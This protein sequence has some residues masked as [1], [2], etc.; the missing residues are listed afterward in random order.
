MSRENDTD[1]GQQV[2]TDELERLAAQGEQD[3]PAEPVDRE[4]AGELSAISTRLGFGEA[5]RARSESAVDPSEVTHRTEA[6]WNDLVELL[7]AEIESATS[8]RQAAVLLYEL[9]HLY[10]MRLR[11]PDR[12]LDAYRRSHER[13]PGLAVNARAL[14]RLLAQAGDASAAERVLSAELSGASNASERV[15]VRLER[16]QLLADQLGEVDRA[17]DELHK[18]LEIDSD[19]G[20]VIQLLRELRQRGRDAGQVELLLRRQL[21]RAEDQSLRALLLTQIGA[22]K[23]AHYGDVEGASKLYQTALSADPGNSHAKRSL[24]RIARVK[25]DRRAAVKLCQ[26]LAAAEE[27]PYAAALLWEAAHLYGE[28]PR[29]G[30]LATSTLARAVELAPTDR[31][32]LTN[33]AQAYEGSRRWPELV[34]TL[35]LIAQQSLDP[36][37]LASTRLRIARL[38]AERLQ[39]VEGAIWNAREAFQLDAGHHGV[40]STLG[41]LYA[42]HGRHA[43]LLELLAAEVHSFDDPERRAA[44]AYRM[45]TIYRQ[46]LDDPAS[47][48]KACEH[49]LELRSGYRP[50]LSAIQE[51]YL[52]QERYEDLVETLEGQVAA[53]A[54]PEEKVVLL[55]RIA[56]L[57]ERSLGDPAAALSAYERMIAIEPANLTA[58]QALRRIYAVGSRW[59]DFVEI[60]RAESDYTP[61]RWR[62]AALLSEIA[63]VYEQRLELPDEALAS[64]LA[65][66]DQ[67]PQY[68]PAL[69]LAGRLL[70]ENGDFERLLAL[71]WQELEA[72]EDAAHRAWL[73]IKIGRVL[74]ERLDRTDDAVGVWL[75]AAKGTDG[76]TAALDLADRA[77]RFLSDTGLQLKVLA[78]Q[79]PP[80][81]PR[82]RSLYHRRMAHALW[83]EG[84]EI[85]AVEQWQSS[86]L[87]AE[88]PGLYELTAAM[89]HLG[90]RRGLVALLEATLENTDGGNPRLSLLHRLIRAFAGLPHESH[91][92]AQTWGR[93]LDQSPRDAIALRQLEILSAQLGRWRDLVAVT[94]LQREHSDDEDFRLGCALVIAAVREDRLDDLAGATQAAIEVLGR[95][96]THSEALATLERH[97]RTTGNADELLQVY[98]R[99]LKG[100][101]TAAE[102]AAMLCASAAVH[103][104]SDRMERACE[105]YRLAIDVMPSYLPAVRGWFRAAVRL[106]DATQMARALEL[107]ARSSRAAERQAACW[108]D[109]AQLWELHGNDPEQAVKG[110]WRV[111][112]IQPRHPAANRALRALL[113][114]RQDF[115]QVIELLEHQIEH[116]ES[117]EETRD[118]L[119]RMAEL[120]RSR[121]EQ[122]TEAKRTLER[123]LELCPQDTQLLST[124]AEL[125]RSSEDYEGLVKA[126]DQLVELTED[127]LLVKALHFESG[128]IWEE[129]LRD[130]ERSIAAYR[131]VLELDP[132]DLGALRHLSTLLFER[133]DWQSA[134]EMTSAL[135]SGTMTERV[136]R[137]TIC[138]LRR[139]MP[140]DSR[141]WSRPWN[142]VA[143]R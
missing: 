3:Q 73:Q 125:C 79:E 70:S 4:L 123:A 72:T 130:A 29:G 117:A 96:E 108:Q 37:Q 134:A 30:D 63:E 92:L 42:R 13:F 8:P 53:S 54:D 110:Y 87:G 68:Q 44:T 47:A 133:K 119:A 90:D 104:N 74:S 16:A 26:A 27:G 56:E 34:E 77:T 118:L 60:L 9:G 19:D 35:E 109:S 83:A 17:C 49:A 91:R 39:D 100:A 12:A 59:Q 131:R 111:L 50:A 102:Q 122:P 126:N 94:E 141:S 105:F 31:A 95:H 14:S 136:S 11:Q 10:E 112:K 82:D 2:L 78:C 121:L 88:D 140:T 93:V 7:L 21:R 36:R 138:G 85:E 81:A 58:M 22:L 25:Q 137:A 28:G 6:S 132:N 107:E 71:H 143:R 75:E 113:T 98:G 23:E 15:A 51:L 66:I 106:D 57:W 32:L 67:V 103:A 114:S 101:Q 116:A 24:L 33:L 46:S 142:S 120:Q 115:A 45:A 80:A 127:L 64:A 76:S 139:S 128:R 18:A 62:R 5:L 97:A 124:L 52:E 69:M 135:R 38:R 1:P 61:D 86:L 55:G 129:R 48:I 89:E 43:E 65:A 84:R 99:Q 40:R 41:R 20:V